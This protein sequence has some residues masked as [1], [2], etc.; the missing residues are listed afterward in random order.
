VL[1]TAVVTF[2][3]CSST[4]SPR[5]ADSL[6]SPKA[7]GEAVV[8]ALNGKDKEALRAVLVTKE[9][10]IDHMWG[11]FPASDHWPADFAYSN[12][13]KNSTKGINRWT[14][15]FGA[16]NYEFL[17]IR[18]TRSVEKYDGFRL[19]RG[20]MLQVRNTKGEEKELRILGSVVEM[21]G[22]FKLLS[23]DEG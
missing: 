23:Y 6:S 3:A 18:F 21:D 4:R 20:T 17:D 9:E 7:V 5:L 12:L 2:L 16:K 15:R 14:E 22:Q 19:H 10:Y 13:N 11:S 8:N 1:A